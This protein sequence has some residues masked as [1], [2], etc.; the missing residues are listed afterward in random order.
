MSC[1]ET[2][3]LHFYSPLNV[4]LKAHN[5][6]I[7]MRMEEGRKAAINLQAKGKMSLVK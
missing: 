6:Q 3:K 2:T 7:E 1:F 5:L 4:V